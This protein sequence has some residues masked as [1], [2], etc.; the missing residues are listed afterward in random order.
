MA[1]VTFA[2]VFQR[3]MAWERRA[4]MK[5][6]IV[7]LASD[8]TTSVVGSLRNL[9]VMDHRPAESDLSPLFLGFALGMR[10]YEEP[11]LPAGAVEFAP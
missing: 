8:V 4:D 11:T 7:W 3:M 9:Q 10:W 5:A 2:D 1:P 6:H